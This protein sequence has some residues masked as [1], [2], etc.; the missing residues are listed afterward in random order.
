MCPLQCN[1]HNIYRNALCRAWALFLTYY[2]Y[3]NFDVVRQQSLFFIGI[4]IYRVGVLAANHRF[5][6]YLYNACKWQSRKSLTTNKR[7]SSNAGNMPSEYWVQYL[8]IMDT[9]QQQQP[10]TTP[11]ENK[12]FAIFCI[13]IFS[14]FP[15][16]LLLL[17]LLLQTVK[18]IS[19]IRRHIQHLYKH[20]ILTR[21][22]F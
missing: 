10:P 6:I 13:H 8:N 11:D 14:L 16:L 21:K 15:L 5:Y 3:Y 17:L 9:P 22:M 2:I 12:R 7:H 20:W 4:G 19:R 18:H 1:R